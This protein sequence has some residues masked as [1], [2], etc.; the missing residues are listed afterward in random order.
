MPDHEHVISR[1]VQLIADSYVFPQRTADIA[2]ALRSRLS[3]GEYE[4]LSGPRSARR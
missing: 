3:A 1:A 4:G 2:S